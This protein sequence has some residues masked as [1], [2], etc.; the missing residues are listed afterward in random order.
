MGLLMFSAHPIGP[1]AYYFLVGWGNC[2]MDF[3]PN[4]YAKLAKVDS[5]STLNSYTLIA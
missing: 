2:N 3:L 5:A 1:D 4:L